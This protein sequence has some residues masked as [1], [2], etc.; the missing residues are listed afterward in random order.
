MNGED[1]IP[2]IMIVEL[3]VFKSQAGFD[4]PPLILYF[5]EPVDR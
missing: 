3:C 4:V 1:A 2:R 5:I